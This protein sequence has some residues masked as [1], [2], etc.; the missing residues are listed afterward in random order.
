MTAAAAA[1]WSRIDRRNDTKTK[2]VKDVM[3]M[4][5]IDEHEPNYRV[6]DLLKEKTN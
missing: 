3:I 6:P 1:L 5:R 2:D 4:K